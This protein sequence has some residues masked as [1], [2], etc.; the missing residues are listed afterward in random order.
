MVPLE[1]FKSHA[2][3]T[4]Y[5]YWT[6][7]L[8]H[9][10]TLLLFS[11]SVMSHASRPHGPQHARLPCPSPPPGVY[12]ISCPSCR[13]CHP[14]ISSSVAPFSFFCQC[15]PASGSFPKS[16]LFTSG[17]W[18]IGVSASVLPMNVQFKIYLLFICLIFVHTLQHVGS[19]FP[20]RGSK[21]YPLHWK[22]K[23]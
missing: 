1:T 20:D 17:D 19:Y 5:L 2:R 13:W 16:L 12:S 11:R 8:C 14:S 9:L 10:L 3:L 7:P 18:S 22:V 15:F 6:V 21:A 4:S 23:S